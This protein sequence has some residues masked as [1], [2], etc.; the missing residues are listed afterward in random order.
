VQPK[1]H[2]DDG[3]DA[4]ASARVRGQDHYSADKDGPHDGQQIDRVAGI[5]QVPWTALANPAAFLVASLF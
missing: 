5:A 4:Q 3:G 2:Q 1:Q